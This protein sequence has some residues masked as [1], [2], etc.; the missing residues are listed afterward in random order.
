[1]PRRPGSQSASSHWLSSSRSR[2]QPYTAEAP[3]SD[4]GSDIQ[5]TVLDNGLR[6]LTKEVYPASVVSL[7]LWVG[8]GALHESDPVAGVSHFIE[9]M[10]FK[11]TPRRPVGRMAQEIHELGGYLNAF[12][13][14]ECTCY[15]MVLPS[16]HFAT[17]LD[18]AADALLHPL[19]DPVEATREAAV[20][21]DE[22]RMYQDRPDYFC[23]EKL[24]RLAF[25]EHRYGRPVIGFE[26][27]LRSMGSPELR[28]HYEQFYAPNNMAVTVV[29][30]V[31]GEEAL[32]RVTEALGAVA[33][34]DVAD[35]R[36]APE[37]PQ[38]A[39]RRLELE[40]D[41]SAAHLQLAFRLPSL[42]AKDA[43]ACEML[44]SILGDGRSSRL[45][46]QLRERLGLVTRIGCST[47]LE[48]DPGLLIV[49]ATLPPEN[50]A[51]AEE[52][53]FRVLDGMSRGV[54]RREM[55]K[56]RNQAESTYVFGQETVEGQGRKLGYYEMLGDYTLADDYVRRLTAVTPSQV[57][58]AARRYL[59]PER[60]SLVSY[61]PAKPA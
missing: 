8:V 43:F 30:D 17:G 26:S 32:H 7:A 27:T 56:A 55:Q 31:A 15:W 21:L 52:E 58:E 28:R 4:L 41:L 54:D 59:K 6:V 1:M 10:L 50:L 11:G 44:A 35:E 20:I 34:R 49:E 48:R 40:G 13:S 33:P 42:F 60:C 38:S 61:R 45:S 14:Y 46:L 22:M 37:P 53:I 3:W 39:M 47:F 25:P 24:L 29:G 9:H 19:F 2:V 5:R 57:V 51:A 18:I 36:P 16:R 23:F 12:T